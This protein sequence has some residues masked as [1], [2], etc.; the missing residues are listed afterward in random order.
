MKQVRRLKIFEKNRHAPTPPCSLTAESAQPEQARA[1][2][3]KPTMRSLNRSFK[4]V[5]G[6]RS[7]AFMTRLRKRLLAFLVSMIPAIGFATTPT[8]AVVSMFYSPD[9]SSIAYAGINDIGQIVFSTVKNNSYLR[10]SDG[11]ITPISF[12]AATNGTSARSINNSGEIVGSYYTQGGGR[13]FIQNPDGTYVDLGPLLASAVNNSGTVVGT[14]SNPVVIQT[15]FIRDSFG[16]VTSFDVGFLPVPAGINDLGQ[17]AGTYCKYSLCTYGAGGTGAFIR[18]ADGS[19][20]TN[21]GLNRLGALNGLP[22]NPVN[23][24]DTFS[25]YGINNAGDI[26]VGASI[27]PPAGSC[28]SYF[29]LHQDGTLDCLL[30]P[31]PAGDISVALLGLNNNG[32]VVGSAGNLANNQGFIGTYSASSSPA[33][34]VRSGVLAHIAAGGGWTTTLSVVNASAS[35]I[36]INVVLHADDGSPLS[37]PVTT[38]QLGLVQTFTGSSVGTTMGPNSTFIIS[39]DG[40]AGSATEGWADVLSSGSVGGFAVFQFTPQSGSSPEGTAPLQTRF[41]SSMILPYDN[42]GGHVMGVALANL[43]GTSADIT[44]TIWDDTGSQLGSQTIAVVGSGHTSFVLPDLLPLTA[45]KR[46]I[47]Q[48]QNTSGG[49]LTVLGLRFSSFGTFTSVPSILTQ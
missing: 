36:D 20:I 33:V 14:Q 11:T 8:V 45:G 12:P 35:S 43:S 31:L 2:F 39:T 28:G 22:A 13:G 24:T 6:K 23:P 41:P 4:C 19:A 27:R 18:N 32:Q 34:A 30:V 3:K 16:D 48:F 46:G 38:T 26:L 49:S 1:C 15:D 10:Q 44:A 25:L 37:L 47:L 9:G 29:L 7:E 5:A 42:T 17:I 21:S 40:Q